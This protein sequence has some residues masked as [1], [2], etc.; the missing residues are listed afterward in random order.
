LFCAG[1][2]PRPIPVVLSALT[3]RTAEWQAASQ[4]GNGRG[5]AISREAKPLGVQGC[6]L[7]HTLRGAQSIVCYAGP[8]TDGQ[9]RDAALWA[10]R[11][12]A[13]GKRGTV[14]ER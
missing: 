12:C 4:S 10:A 6:P 8:P 9:N 11:F 3:P 5:A 7:P 2:V 14:F 13:A 1:R